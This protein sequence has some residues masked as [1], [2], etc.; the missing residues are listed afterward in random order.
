MTKLNPGDRV[1]CRVKSA[2]IVSPYKSYDEIL[3]FEVIA[4][5][6]NGYYL[7]V[8]HYFYLIESVV[9]DQYRCKTLGIDKRFLN[10]NMVYIQENM[11]DHVHEAMTGIKCCKCLEFYN[12][13]VPNQFDGTL[14][15]W[16]CRQNHYR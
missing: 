14:I 9:A 6:A 3:T 11:I 8:P 13:A 5:D 12:Y 7:Y 4:R 16:S 2:T 10:E 15:C 1:D